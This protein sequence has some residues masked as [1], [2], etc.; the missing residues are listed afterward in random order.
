MTSAVSMKSMRTSLTQRSTRWARLSFSAAA[1]TACG[2]FASFSMSSRNVRASSTVISR[3]GAP[4]SV[5]IS[6]ASR[7]GRASSWGSTTA[8]SR[9]DDT[10]SGISVAYSTTSKSPSGSCKLPDLFVTD[11][12]HGPRQLLEEAAR[13]RNPARGVEATED[14]A[15]AHQR[16]VAAL[17]RWFGVGRVGR[18]APLG[19]DGR[20]LRPDELRRARG[21][22]PP[23]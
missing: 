13:D 7:E 12:D 14:D 6:S 2:G 22:T 4:P 9:C 23:N 16:L 20:S 8:L 1:A 3:T 17:L 21:P 18:S 19:H 5:L 11:D 15:S 10:F